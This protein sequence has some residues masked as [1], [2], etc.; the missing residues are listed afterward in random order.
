[1]ILYVIVLFSVRNCWNCECLCSHST[2]RKPVEDVEASTSLHPQQNSRSLA[3][4]VF[5]LQSDGHSEFKALTIL[6]PS[7]SEKTCSRT[8][9][10]HTVSDAPSGRTRVMVRSV[11]NLFWRKDPQPPKRSGRPGCRSLF[12]IES[13]ENNQKQPKT[14]EPPDARRQASWLEFFWGTC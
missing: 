11:W 13:F 12:A 2:S 4:V 8:D 6:I 10:L 5:F 9:R 7:K 3:W 14:P 1:M